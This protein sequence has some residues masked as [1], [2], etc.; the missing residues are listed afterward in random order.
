MTIM[1]YDYYENRNYEFS[2]KMTITVI[3]ARQRESQWKIVNS[4]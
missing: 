1:K 3:D 2:L 4:Y